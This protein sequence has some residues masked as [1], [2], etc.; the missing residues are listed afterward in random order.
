MAIFASTTTSGYSDPLKALSIKALE[1]RQKDMLA[2]SAADKPDAA[3]MATIP[4]GIGS[5][6]GIIGDKMAQGRADQALVD[7]RAELAKTMSGYNADQG[8]TG[9]QAASLSR[10]APEIL[11]KLMQH[12]QER[13]TTK[14]TEAG[15]GGRNAATIAGQAAT[16]AATNA[17][18][19]ATNK[20]TNET[21]AANNAATIAGEAATNAA[22]NATSVAT[23]KL[24]NETSAANNAATVGGEG[25]RLQTKVEADKAAAAE[26]AQ[27]AEAQK[28]ADEKRFLARP[29]EDAIAKINL[30]EKNNEITPEQAAAERKKSMAPPEATAEHI[31]KHQGES[32]EAQSALST[33]DEAEAL[34]NHPKGIHAGNYAG[35]TQSI[36]EKVPKFMQGGSLVPDPETTKNTTR[37]NQIMGAEALNLLTQMKGASSDKDV[38][39]NFKIA[40]D[41]DAPIEA[42]RMAIGVLKTKLAAHLAV[43]NEAITN[44]GGK[45][46]ALPGAGAPAAPAAAAAKGGPGTVVPAAA[47]AVDPLEG[48]T[49]NGPDGPIIRRNGKWEKQ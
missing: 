44:A 32:V 10:V 5:V 18:S 45:V 41:P 2:Q 48:R 46:P 21:S 9:E 34:L 38:Q 19:I 39:V 37:Y 29:S 7:N 14:T 1:Q 24:T 27:V 28:A 8:L 20:L 11:E 31:V 13:W 36:G 35:T 23:N 15:L 30:A 26:A 40:N 6:L 49:A 33:L 25:A 3:M 16:N 4:G 17:T 12:Q 43:E 42:K 22:T 47:A